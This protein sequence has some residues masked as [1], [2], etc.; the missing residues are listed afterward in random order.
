[1]YSNSFL[2]EAFSFS[3]ARAYRFSYFYVN[4]FQIIFPNGA[5]PSKGNETECNVISKKS[6]RINVNY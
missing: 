4:I 5:F 6:S 1:M 2:L 3:P